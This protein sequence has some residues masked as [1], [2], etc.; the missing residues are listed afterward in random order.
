[1][2]TT[3]TNCGSAQPDTSIY[4]AQCGAALGANSDGGHLE[5]WRGAFARRRT[6]FLIST[7]GAF[8]ALLVFVAR[9][10]QYPESIGTWM[11]VVII[12]V[13]AVGI[14]NFLAF[15]C[16]KCGAHFLWLFGD[17]AGIWFFTNCPKCGL[18][19]RR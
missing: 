7:L 16:P 3:C 11:P 5:S 2:T 17:G 12:L 9:A 1:M 19:L 4:C 15:R 13:V 8:A 18:R 10:M 14:A 6:F